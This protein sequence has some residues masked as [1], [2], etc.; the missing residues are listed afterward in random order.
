MADGANMIIVVK[1]T[2]LHVQP[3]RED[4]VRFRSRS[5]PL[6]V[7]RG[8]PDYAST[9]L[10]GD[11]PQDMVVCPEDVPLKAFYVITLHTSH[12]SGSKDQRIEEVVKRLASRSRFDLPQAPLDHP[13]RPSFEASSRRLNRHGDT[14]TRT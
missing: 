10:D 13:V 3:L 7:G 14:M 12:F 2:F 11:R 9:E 6:V 4:T 1:N 5:T 8:C